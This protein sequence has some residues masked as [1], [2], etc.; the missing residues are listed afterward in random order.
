[1]NITQVSYCV[2]GI[3]LLISILVD[4]AAMR[5][6]G[7]IMS[8]KSAL[9]QFIAWFALALAYGIFL[10]FQFNSRYFTTYIS[11][12]LVE[13]S[14]S[15]DNIFVF[16]LLFGSFKIKEQDLGRLLLIG[17]LLAIILRFF[18]IIAGIELVSRF[19]WILYIF[20]GIL[21]YTG[22]KLFF[23]QEEQEDYD[24]KQSK[25]YKIANK[26]FR[27]DYNDD[28][29]GFIKKV[30][31][32]MYLTKIALAVLLLA[33]T[34]VMFAVDSIPAVLSISQ[35]RL[36]VFSSNVFAILGLRPLY[37]L[38]RAAADKFD[39]LQQGI[40]AILVFIGAKLL[41]AVVKIHI[42]EAISLAVIVACLSSSIIISYF[43][44]K[45]K[46]Q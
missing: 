7:G 14:L 23:K 31:G 33:V 37:F 5:R 44:N 34:D 24:P 41:L 27:I 18:F 17:V 29:R 8:V 9:V 16:I 28:D 13:E 32:K 42:S 6:S 46:A 1:M 39:F 22:A 40:A 30:D 36:I 43:Y 11:A 2:F 19:N 20:G 21:V 15:I 25:F 45:D 3:A 35:N 4:F 38:L 26:L 12:Y 10:Y